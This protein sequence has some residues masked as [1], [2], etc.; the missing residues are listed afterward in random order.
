MY[1]SFCRRLKSEPSGVAIAA[2]AV[3]TL[4][5]TSA[6]VSVDLPAF[7]APTTP[8]CSSCCCSVGTIGISGRYG[9]GTYSVYCSSSSIS[10]QTA[11]LLNTFCDKRRGAV[12]LTEPRSAPIDCLEASS[13]KLI[14]EQT[15]GLLGPSELQ[16]EHKVAGRRSSIRAFGTRTACFAREL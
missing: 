8:T 15:R 4:V 11:K 3:R 7:G 13:L 16:V 9:C 5:P 2:N 14:N 6:L 1:G 10:S 12:N